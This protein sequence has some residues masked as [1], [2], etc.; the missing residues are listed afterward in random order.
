[1]IIMICQMQRCIMS[2]AFSSTFMPQQCWWWFKSCGMLC[3]VDWL[4]VTDVLEDHTA[5]VMSCWLVNS[6]WCLGGSY[7]LHL[8]GQGVLIWDCLTLK[9]KALQPWKM[10]GTTQPPTQ[11]HFLVDLNLWPPQ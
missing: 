2:P 4:I 11:C 5:D 8:Q 10:L 6:Y 1:M 7:C 3:H 9:T